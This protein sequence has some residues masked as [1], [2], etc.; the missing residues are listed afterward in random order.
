MPFK[1]PISGNGFY[2]LY[3]LSRKTRKRKGEIQNSSRRKG[4]RKLKGYR[5]RRG[6]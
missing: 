3:F 4:D 5:G 2:V 1:N 6:E